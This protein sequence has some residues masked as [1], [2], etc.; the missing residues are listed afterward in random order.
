LTPSGTGP[1]PGWVQRSLGTSRAALLAE[2]RHET[3]TVSQLAA[4]VGLSRNAVRAHL[5]RL[6]RDG[7]VERFTVHR[8]T[9]GKPAFGYRV[10]GAASAALSTAYA[11]AAVHLLDGIQERVSPT[12]LRVLLRAV[13]RSL[14]APHRGASASFR[15][16]VGDAA[17]AL[18]ALGGRARVVERD[19]GLSVE[20][21]PCPLAALTSRHAS[22]CQALE[23][24]VG[25]IAGA[26]AVHHCEH[27]SHPRCR[28]DVRH[29]ATA[30]DASG[31]PGE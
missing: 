9:P 2:L 12:E 28:F 17:L 15:T 21:V 29:R 8:A 7:L 30:S 13:G 22:A 14:A 3:A 4:V 26:P 1:L 11:P 24:L 31:Y 10:T 20:S 23:A 19:D 5:S 27:G 25:E 16:R 18:T 6:E